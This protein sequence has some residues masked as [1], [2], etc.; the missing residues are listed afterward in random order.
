MLAEPIVEVIDAGKT[1]PGG[2]IAVDGLSFTLREGEFVSLLGPSGCGKSTALRMVAGLGHPTC[3]EIRRAW[4]GQPSSSRQNIGCVFQDPTLLPWTSTWQNVYLPL[5]LAGV[6]RAAARERVDEALA[7]VGLAEFAHAYPRQLS[8]GMKMRA[9]IA[10][11]LVTRPRLVLLDEPLAALDEITRN[12]L[13]DE[14]L[15]FWRARRWT[16]LF[17]THSVFESVYLSTRVLVMS[18]RPGRI[19][20]DIPVD[21]PEVR[22]PETRTGPQYINLCRQVSAALQRAMGDHASGAISASPNSAAPLPSAEMGP[23]EQGR[24]EVARAQDGSPREATGEGG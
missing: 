24:P 8:G 22:T 20:E 10:R 5:R 6:G 11:A 14:L 3:G 21:L 19:V 13:N 1:Y 7:T 23:T 4:E 17:I 9:S 2:A 18:A 15:T 12:W 16:V